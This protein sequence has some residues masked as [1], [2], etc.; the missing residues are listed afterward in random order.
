MRELEKFKSEIVEALNNI[1]RY[2]DYQN[3]AGRFDINKDAEEFYRGLLNL[4]FGWNLKNANSDKYPNFPGVDLLYLGD[5]IAVQITSENDSEK[6]HQS[7]IGFKNKALKEGCSELYILMFMGKQDF[8]RADFAGTV[9]GQFSFDKN[10]HIIDHSDLCVKLN[11]AEFDY[12]KAIWDYLKVWKCIA[13]D[14]L[15]GSILDLGIIGEI[16]DYI[17]ANKPKKLS[18]DET[19]RSSASIELFPKIKLNFPEEQQEEISRF[20]R[21]AWDKK[22]I[23]RQFLEKQ[24]DDDEISV[25]ELASTIQ[26]DYCKLKECKNSD[27]RVEDIEII[28]KLALVY[29]PDNKKGNIGYIANAEA[30]VLHFFEFCF[31]GKKTNECHQKSLFDEC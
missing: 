4:F 31:I 11:N 16:F 29:L 14:N 27:T 7:I 9:D 25:Y 19:I 22:E 10:K 18:N 5:K 8:P 23:V 15:D 26:D 17:Q 20:I 1:T 21:R 12:V 2:A 3:K 13:Y 24:S 6:V 28:R 30:L